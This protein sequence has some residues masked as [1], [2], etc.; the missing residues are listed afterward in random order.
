MQTIA[1]TKSNLMSLKA[2]LEFSKNG[3]ELL[4]RKRNVL[5]REMMGYIDRARD[6]QQNK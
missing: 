3:Y 1:P 4:D 2:T 6:I 5:I